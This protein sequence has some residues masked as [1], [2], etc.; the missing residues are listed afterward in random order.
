[1]ESLIGQVLFGLLFGLSV[2]VILFL[3]IAYN[4]TADRNKPTTTKK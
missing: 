4:I 2:S 1:M 3:T